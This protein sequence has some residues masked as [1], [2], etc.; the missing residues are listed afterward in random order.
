VYEPTETPPRVSPRTAQ[1]AADAFGPQ[2]VRRSRLQMPH[3]PVRSG[4]DET[5]TVSW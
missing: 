1:Q 4:P 3:V 5:A 2:Q